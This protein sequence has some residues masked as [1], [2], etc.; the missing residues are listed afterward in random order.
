MNDRQNEILPILHGVAVTI[1]NEISLVPLLTRTLQKLLY[2]TS[3]PAG[4]IVLELPPAATLSGESVNAR[5]AAVVGDY[6]LRKSVGQSPSLPAGLVFGPTELKAD[7][8]GLLAALPATTG[9]YRAFLRLPID[10]AGVVLLMAPELPESNLPVTQMFK[11]SMAQLAKA[12][13]L[14]RRHDAYTSGLIAE[15]DLSEARRRLMAEVFE[16]SYAGVVITDAGGK[17]VAV[18]PAFSRITGQ[19]AEAVTAM[20]AESAFGCA[21]TD[22]FGDG[23]RTAA[24]GGYWQG[25]LM[26]RRPDGEHYPVWLSISPV[27]A[28]NGSTSHYVGIFSDIS[29]RKQAEARIRFLAH[30]DPLTQL[31]NRILVRERFEE[32][33]AVADRDGSR[34]ALIFVDLDN[35]KS[36]NDSLGHRA[37]DRALEIIASRL[38]EQWP[39]PATVGRQGGDEFTVIAPLAGDDEGMWQ[40]IR[41]IRR[42]IAEPMQ[43]GEHEVVIESSIGISLYPGHGHDF[44]TLL[45]HADTAMYQAKADGG[46][47]CC[48]FDQAMNDRARQRFELAGQLRKSIEAGDFELHYQPLVECAGGRI[49]GAEALLRWRHPRRGM[50]S[51]VEFIPLAEETGLIVPLGAWVL[52]EA[53]RQTAH[54]RA[55]G[56]SS[57]RIAVNL[58]ALQL[59]RGLLEQTVEQALAQSG[60]EPGA[61]ELEITES[62]LLDQ[63]A[64]SAGQIQRLR[65]LGITIS[66]D[67]FGTGYSSLSYLRRFRVDKL[68]IDRGFLSNVHQDADS[69]LLV[70]TILQLGRGLGIRTVAE[71][72]E[73]SEQ[74][75][76]VGQWGCDELQGYW[77][78]PPLPAADFTALLHRHPPNG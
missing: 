18:N 19:P 50:V 63:T 64:E 71:G 72:I 21:E 7:A 54:W 43:I 45:Q 42:R 39:E 24:T 15:R 67:D 74:A 77:F 52:A 66:L 60:L 23:G 53:C 32:A 2:Y 75:Q 28:A 27:R 34:L 56:H 51:P 59:R 10:A 25:E 30:H 41:E 14:C 22:L 11:P 16:S 76:L 65:G 1:G 46:K 38:L 17:V 49:T 12:I 62:V 37:G 13:E 61:L 29:Q 68:K 70:R 20:Q 4:L 9:D 44:D 69:A 26:N 35:F 78:S 8:S 31:P 33:S 48:L 47:V 55:A 57:L 73:T 40:A 58:S 5:V 36:I 6:D 3:F